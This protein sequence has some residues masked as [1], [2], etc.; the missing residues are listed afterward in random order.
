MSFQPAAAAAAP[1][2][3][4]L[5]EFE[6]VWL[7]LKLSTGRHSTSLSKRLKVLPQKYSVSESVGGSLIVSDWKKLSH[8]R[9]FLLCEILFKP[10]T[11]ADLQALRPIFVCTLVSFLTKVL[12]EK[13]RRSSRSL[14]WQ[15]LV[16]VPFWE[17][18]SMP[19]AIFLSLS[20]SSP[21]VCPHQPSWSPNSTDLYFRYLFVDQHRNTN[22]NDKDHLVG[23]LPTTNPPYHSLAF[24]KAFLALQGLL[25]S[26]FKNIMECFQKISL[27]CSLENQVLHQKR[28]VFKNILEFKWNQSMQ[29][30]Y[31]NLLSLNLALQ[32]SLVIVCSAL[33]GPSRNPLKVC[34]TSHK[35]SLCFD[36]PPLPIHGNRFSFHSAKCHSVTT[37]IN[38]WK[39]VSWCH[40]KDVKVFFAF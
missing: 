8:L 4:V 31:I 9:A 33:V 29:Q 38:W 22:M 39:K 13:Q 26:S 24:P 17:Y 28:K 19:S 20:L 16:R 12:S 23:Q 21:I 7:K 36:A 5:I 2:A 18:H 10:L 11:R 15:N 32:S 37:V 35:S 30:N 40:S 6:K 25:K 1:W 34:R 3:M 14:L 27:E